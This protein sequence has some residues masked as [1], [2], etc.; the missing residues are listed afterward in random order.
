MKPRPF[1]KEIPMMK[2]LFTVAFLSL[3]LT[4]AAF[5]AEPTNGEAGNHGDSTAGGSSSNGGNGTAPGARSVP[6][7][8]VPGPVRVIPCG[9]DAYTVD[10]NGYFRCNSSN[11]GARG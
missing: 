4:A 5:A 6:T 10:A 8:Y 3:S 9:G 11:A 2:L 1:S 7:I